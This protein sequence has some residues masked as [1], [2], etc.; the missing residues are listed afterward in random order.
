MNQGQTTSLLYALG[1]RVT[2]GY[3]VK[4]RRLTKVN[5]I[6]SKASSQHI[7]EQHLTSNLHANIN[8]KSK[9]VPSKYNL[10]SGRLP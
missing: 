5:L 6:K 3:T 10:T 7:T 1:R 8:I 9:P 4:A 2:K